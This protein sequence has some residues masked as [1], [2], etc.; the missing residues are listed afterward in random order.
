MMN[1]NEVSSVLVQ[2]DDGELGIVTD[3][4]LR[5]RMMACSH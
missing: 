2:I 5:S 4:D 1:A 3:R